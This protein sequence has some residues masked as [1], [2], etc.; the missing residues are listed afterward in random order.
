MDMKDIKKLVLKNPLVLS[1]SFTRINALEEIYRTV[2]IEKEKYR[3]LINN[4]DKALSVNP[5]ELA[6]SVSNLQKNGYGREKIAD[7]IM[8]NPYLVIKM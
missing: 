1:E 5:K 8:R 7:T 3:D 2:G 4:F 6:E